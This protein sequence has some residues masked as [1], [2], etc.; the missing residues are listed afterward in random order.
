MCIWD[1]KGHTERGR[2]NF[3]SSQQMSYKP[4]NVYSLTGFPLFVC[5]CMYVHMCV[6]VSV[7][8]SVCIF[9]CTCVYTCLGGGFKCVYMLQLDD[10]GSE[11]QCKDDFIFRFCISPLFQNIVCPVQSSGEEGHIQC[12]LAFHD[13]S[14]SSS[15]CRLMVC[16]GPQP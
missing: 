10:F 15:Q 8:G 14:M 3:T 11:L 2:V 12:L 7:C 6:C 1:G 4:C 9:V 13:F 16:M 5:V